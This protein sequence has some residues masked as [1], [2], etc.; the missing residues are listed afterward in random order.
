MLYPATS[1]SQAA[2]SAHLSAGSLSAKLESAC[3]ELLAE[4]NVLICESLLTDMS[5][6]GCMSN[7]VA[8]RTPRFHQLTMRGVRLVYRT[9]LAAVIG[10][11]VLLGGTC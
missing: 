7:V 4:A 11:V 6:R 8:V 5:R 9:L 3:N 10:T 1:C 2:C